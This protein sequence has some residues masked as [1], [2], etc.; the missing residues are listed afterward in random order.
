MQHSRNVC[1]P[2]HHIRCHH[3][4]YRRWR[5]WYDLKWI[6]MHGNIPD[7]IITQYRE[8]I[9]SSKCNLWRQSSWDFEWCFE[10]RSFKTLFTKASF[11]QSRI[12]P[13]VSVSRG[14]LSNFFSNKLQSIQLRKTV[15]Q[16]QLNSL[17]RKFFSSYLQFVSFEINI[18]E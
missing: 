13:E 1:L 15:R 2:L 6:M 8:R 7:G 9:F 10:T 17:G 14:N 18:M 12:Y 11:S 16:P 4:S 5:R 3:H